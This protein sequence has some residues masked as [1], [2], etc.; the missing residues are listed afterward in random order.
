MEDMKDEWGTDGTWAN[1]D[2][3][4][5][6][7]LMRHVYENREEAKEKGKIASKHILSNFTWDHAAK[8]ALELLSL[9]TTGETK[10]K[11]TIKVIKPA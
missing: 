5:L 2:V 6:R 4:H 9:G 7:H 1:P 3:M 8:K 10:N 11:D